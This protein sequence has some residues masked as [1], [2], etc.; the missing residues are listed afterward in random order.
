MAF[1]QELQ[2]TT[3]ETKSDAAKTEQTGKRT[4]TE[5]GATTTQR[6]PSEQSDDKQARLASLI[7]E[8]EAQFVRRP[9]HAK[10]IAV[11]LSVEFPDRFDAAWVLKTYGDIDAAAWRK[12]KVE[13]VNA[14]WDDRPAVAKAAIS[15]LRARYRGDKALA[16]WAAAMEKQI[17]AHQLRLRLEAQI[18]A[19][20]RRP[21][22]A[23]AAAREANRLWPRQY[24]KSWLRKFE[25]Q[26]WS[27]QD[28]KWAERISPAELT[29]A[30]GD[31]VVD[32]DDAPLEVK[33]ELQIR[34]GRKKAEQYYGKGGGGATDDRALVLTDASRTEV[35]E[36]SSQD[37][38]F[39][40]TKKEEIPV[41][42]LDLTARQY[43][44]KA[45]ELESSLI[46]T[47]QESGNPLLARRP[48]V[49]TT[50]FN[51]VMAKQAEAYR[52]RGTAYRTLVANIQS[53]KTTIAA[54]RELIKRDLFA[55]DNELRNQ[56]P[57][58]RE[59]EKQAKTDA[60]VSDKLEATRKVIQQLEQH[61]A[62]LKQVL[63]APDGVVPGAGQIAIAMPGPSMG[64]ASAERT[65]A[66]R[67]LYGVIDTLQSVTGGE[68]PVGIQKNLQEMGVGLIRFK[69]RFDMFNAGVMRMVAN[70][71]SYVLPESITAPIL[72]MA[73]QSRALGLAF[74]TANTKFTKDNEAIQMKYTA[75]GGEI[76]MID[77]VFST[78]KIFEK[79]DV[80][81]LAFIQAMPQTKG[82]S[83]AL[84]VGITGAQTIEAFFAT[85]GQTGQLT[86]ALQAAGWSA[87]MGA[88][89]IV[90]D[91]LGLPPSAA[92]ISNITLVYGFGKLR[93]LTT[94]Q[95]EEE[96]AF[97]LVGAAVG[98]AKSVTKPGGSATLEGVA[99][100]SREIAAALD[101][102]T[103]AKTESKP[104]TEFT[105]DD[106]AK[107]KKID[108]AA[109]DLAAAIEG[110][111]AL[112][113]ELQRLQQAKQP[114]QET[115]AQLKKSVAT[116]DQKR[117]ALKSALANPTVGTTRISTS[118][119]D[120]STVEPTV[121]TP[122][123]ETTPTVATR[124]AETKPTSADR[125]VA[126]TI[127]TDAVLPAWL[128]RNNAVILK[129]ALEAG[130]NVWTNTGNTATG[131]IPFQ[132]GLTGDFTKGPTAG[133]KEAQSLFS[134]TAD[135]MN[136]SVTL[137]GD[138]TGYATSEMATSEV[139]SQ[140]ASPMA[141]RGRVSSVQDRGD[142]TARVDNL[143]MSNVE[144]IS[145]LP[146]VKNA[147]GWSKAFVELTTSSGLKLDPASRGAKFLADIQDVLTTKP[148]YGEDDGIGRPLLNESEV[149]DALLEVFQRYVR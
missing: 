12:Q 77:R 79:P 27:F 46:P 15:E 124:T 98:A 133:V 63:D 39:T 3:G 96:I 120:A 51:D 35:L 10:Q 61:E 7:A 4:R 43:D 114:T 95:I 116:T 99:A 9:A 36:K 110:S 76:P 48:D 73:E 132:R 115:V 38:G 97:A 18:R 58:L 128:P 34:L 31:N 47:S 74:T 144:S 44:K 118:V 123:V 68:N 80:A 62:V 103:G 140:Y 19:W 101:D 83:L 14:A 138:G 129:S 112:M 102:A 145:F 88:A 121:A 137:Y 54:E 29:A 67:Q 2:Q 20:D 42:R 109:N 125:T 126:T 75:A 108:D 23:Q 16:R 149:N 33:Q 92:L 100:K 56:Y 146:D 28:V 113:Q 32:W 81:I 41:K 37:S 40:F 122:T 131:D 104:T 147:I 84:Q 66:S 69:G 87:V 21:G 134:G 111:R 78:Q 82:V 130:P 22:E 59:Y 64:P 148:K 85:Y 45:S 135:P 117:A 139:T 57:Q 53:G 17:D 52:S 106:L 136:R 107:S 24:P 89:G 60:S 142:T 70:L 119:T 49:M 72:G 1:D 143:S 71:G 50:I 26:T 5:D 90:L 25:Q 105:A 86:P 93:G 127:P 65:N 30:L 11:T 8:L 94:A 91:K 55:I 141:V 13:T 6:E